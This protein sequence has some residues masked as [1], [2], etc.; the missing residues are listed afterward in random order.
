[1]SHRGAQKDQFERNTKGH[2]IFVDFA[3]DILILCF[4]LQHTATHKMASLPLENWPTCQFNP[5]LLP[6]FSSHPHSTDNAGH[7]PHPSMRRRPAI[8]SQCAR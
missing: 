4:S 2:I 8:S 6:L 3:M 5:L 7:I 1:M